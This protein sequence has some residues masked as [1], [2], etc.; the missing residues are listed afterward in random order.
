MGRS[1]GKEWRGG[2]SWRGS[3]REGVVSTWVFCKG[4]VLLVG[5]QLPSWSLKEGVRLR[6]N[7]Q[8]RVKEYTPHCTGVDRHRWETRQ[9]LLAL[10]QMSVGVPSFFPVSYLLSSQF[11]HDTWVSAA[12]SKDSHKQTCTWKKKF[13]KLTQNNS[14][15]HNY[16]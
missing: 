16:Y 13:T 5:G 8:G 3:R 2:V 14:H 12:N 10:N 11:I 7:V 6:L 9:S 4:E 15:Y 1:K